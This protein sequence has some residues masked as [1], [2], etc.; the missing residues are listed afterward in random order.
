MSCGQRGIV[1]HHFIPTWVSS[2]RD[3]L[4]HDIVCHQEV[5]L[6]LKVTFSF[7]DSIH[8]VAE[9]ILTSSTHQPSTAA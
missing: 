8:T 7:Q 9:V 2:A 5:R 3:T 6:Q 1:A 4:V